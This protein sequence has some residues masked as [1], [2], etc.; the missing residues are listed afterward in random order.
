MNPKQRFTSRVEYFVKYRPGYPRQILDCL[1]KQCRLTAESVVAD[2]GSGTGILA[3]IFL[4]HGNRVFGVEPNP[5]M[6]AAGESILR[7]YPNFLSV[8]GSAEDT[9]LPAR[10]V[11]FIV[12]GQAFHWFNPAAARQEFRRILK[13]GGYVA[14]IWNLRDVTATP[15]L[16]AYENL[17]LRFATDYKAINRNQVNRNSLKTLFG[18]DDYRSEHFRNE[19]QFD[20]EALK[21]RLLSSSYTPLPGDSSYAP[22]LQRLREIFDKFAKNGQVQFRYKTR[23]IYGKLEVRDQ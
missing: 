2:I 21:G 20:Y 1:I 11:D 22:M 8:D 18:S 12:S 16:K 6:R 23:L 15:F 14:L 17:L 19:Q 9:A 10:S 7:K 5:E 13:P 3:E 4:N